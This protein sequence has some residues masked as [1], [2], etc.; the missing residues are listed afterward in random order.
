MIRCWRNAWCHPSS[1]A[2]QRWWSVDTLV[3]GKWG[4]CTKHFAHCSKWSKS[5]SGKQSVGVLSVLYWPA[6]ASDLKTCWALPYALTKIWEVLQEPWG[7]ISEDGP[8]QLTARMPKTCKALISPM[9][10]KSEGQTCWFKW[11]KKNLTL[12]MSMYYFLRLSYY[13]SIKVWAFTDNLK[14][15]ERLQTSERRCASQM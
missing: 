2:A 3:L 11:K 12:S 6:H 13:N 1:M 15:S 4:I 7:D 5:Y 10:A 14:F 9:K 8:D